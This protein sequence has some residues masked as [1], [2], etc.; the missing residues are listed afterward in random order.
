MEHSLGWCWGHRRSLGWLAPR[1]HLNSDLR[2]SQHVFWHSQKHRWLLGS[3]SNFCLRYSFT[4]CL[5]TAQFVPRQ[6]IESEAQV[7]RSDRVYCGLMT[8]D[9]VI[10]ESPAKAKT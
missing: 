3:I 9:L 6:E 1:Q 8:K 5:Y 2:T 4:V 10:V 7:R